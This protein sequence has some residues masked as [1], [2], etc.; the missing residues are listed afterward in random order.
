MNDLGVYIGRIAKTTRGGHSKH[1]PN[2]LRRGPSVPDEV[3]NHLFIF[4]P[5]QRKNP[6]RRRE[7]GAFYDLVV[8]GTWMVNPGVSV[9]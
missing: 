2:A 3:L 9:H 1:S 6:I 8:P 4:P 7:Y 5:K